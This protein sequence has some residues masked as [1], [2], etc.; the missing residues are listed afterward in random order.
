MQYMMYRGYRTTA[1][2]EKGVLLFFVDLIQVG[3]NHLH[4]SVDFTAMV[5]KKLVKRGHI[6]LTN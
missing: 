5:V 1:V 2:L 6:A 3:G 4:R